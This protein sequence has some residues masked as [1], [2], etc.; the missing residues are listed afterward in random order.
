VLIDFEAL[1]KVGKERGQGKVG[2][3]FGSQLGL[4]SRLPEMPLKVSS[5]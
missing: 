5:V 2:I 1:R 4:D 3:A